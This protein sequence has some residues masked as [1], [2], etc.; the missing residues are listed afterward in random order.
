MNCPSSDIV[1]IE[2]A[3]LSDGEKVKQLAMSFDLD[4]EDFSIHQFYVAKS[5]T[6][7]VGFGRL[8]KYSSC[9]EVATVGVIPEERYKG[10]GTAIVNELIKSGPK[11]LF[12]TC[13]IPHFFERIGF[14]TVKHYPEVLRKKV[15]FCKLYDFTEDQIF[16]MKISK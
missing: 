13:V 12:V 11:E 9:T 14:E 3:G 7:I 1:S 15:N 6:E 5:N 10:I 16:V 4:C 8:R 2:A